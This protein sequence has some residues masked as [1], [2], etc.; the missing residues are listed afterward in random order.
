MPEKLMGPKELAAWLDVPLATIYRWNSDGHGPRRVSVGRHTRYAE[1][2]VRTWLATR[3][4][5]SA[6]AGGA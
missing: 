3:T 2:D 5:E 6:A 4:V 1:A